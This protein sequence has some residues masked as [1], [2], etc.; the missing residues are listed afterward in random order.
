MSPPKLFVHQQSSKLVNAE[1]LTL[2]IHTTDVSFP[3]IA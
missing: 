1:W 3:A 2:A